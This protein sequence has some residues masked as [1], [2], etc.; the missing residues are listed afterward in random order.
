M[1]KERRD[2]GRR[3]RHT[4]MRGHTSLLVMG[5]YVRSTST[6]FILTFPAV[7]ADVEGFRRGCQCWGF[8]AYIAHGL[9]GIL[10]CRNRGS[11]ERN[12]HASP[13]SSSET[14]D[15]SFSSPESHRALQPFRRCGCRSMR[16]T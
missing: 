14:L 13:V 6:K 15:V 12:R 10:V 7:D 4:N 11:K 8:V 1:S 16:R 9:A 2:G 5:T 3:E